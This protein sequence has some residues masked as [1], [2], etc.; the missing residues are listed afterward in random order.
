MHPLTRFF[1]YLKRVDFTLALA[2][3]HIDDRE[4]TEWYPE[5]IYELM[6]TDEVRNRAY[7]E[8]IRETVS[9]KIVLE[10]GT[11]RKALWAVFCAKAGAKKVYAIE[12][13]KKAYQAS[14]DHVR[15]QGIENIHLICGFSDK[16]QLPERCE[17]L[18]HDLVGDIG[19]SEGMIPFIEDAKRRLLT[20]AAV[21]IPQRCATHVVLAED[22]RLRPV[23]WALS[24]G[25]RGFR[26]F[27]ELPFV[28]FFGFPDS[29][30]LSEP[31]VF[32]DFSLDQ[33]LPLDSNMQLVF[34]ILRDGELRG[35]C[36][37]I[38]LYLSKTHIVDTWKSQ[39]SWSTPYVRL[40]A[41]VP[42]KKGDLVEM[43]IRSD[44][45]AN[46]SYALR[47]MHKADGSAREIGEYAWSGD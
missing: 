22:P 5:W 38:R 28:R 18:V 23:E 9:D 35:V 33:A 36:F 14:L 40:K 46:P 7:C 3:E 26:R 45:S 2:R 17:V 29:A 12:A 13:N 15:S 6:E 39:T 47:L 32:E 11:G 4:L 34:K 27:D 41:P 44:L 10:L 43:C 19:S 21:H 30:V 20:P 1:N 24:Y 16:V 37:F 8:A 25:L 42:V 31:L